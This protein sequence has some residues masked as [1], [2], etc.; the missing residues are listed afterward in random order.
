MQSKY[1]ESP[2]LGHG[3]SKAVRCLKGL[4]FRGGRQ[5]GQGRGEGI[6]YYHLSSSS[7]YDSPWDEPRRSSD[8]SEICLDDNMDSNLFDTDF[9]ERQEPHEDFTELA[10]VNGNFPEV[11]EKSGGVPELSETNED[12]SEMINTGQDFPNTTETGQDVSGLKCLNVEFL[13]IMEKDENL[14]VLNKMDGDFVECDESSGSFPEITGPCEEHKHQEDDGDFKV[15]SEWPAE[16]SSCLH[17]T[18][19][20]T[21]F[22]STLKL[23]ENP[24]SELERIVTVRSNP[25][26]K[27]AEETSRGCQLSG[28]RTSVEKPVSKR[29]VQLCKAVKKEKSSVQGSSALV[30]VKQRGST[31]QSSR[32]RSDRSHGCR[33]KGDKKS[34]SHRGC[35]MNDTKMKSRGDQVRK[36][37]KTRPHGDQA[38]DD[39]SK[40]SRGVQATRD[41]TKDMSSERTLQIYD[42]RARLSKSLSWLLR[43]SAED[44]GLTL[45][46][47]GFLPVED[48]LRVPAFQGYSIS[49]IKDVV[50]NDDK[51]R[52]RLVL[53]HGSW[54]IKANS[55]HTISI[56]GVSGVSSGSHGSGRLRRRRPFRRDRLVTLSRFLAKILRHTAVSNGLNVMKGGFL[57][58]DDLLKLS[59]LRH[60]R[61]EDV[62]KVVD[63]D[64]KTRFTLSPDEENLM[65]KIRANRGHTLSFELESPACVRRTKIPV[66]K[67]RPSTR[68]TEL[69]V[70]TKALLPEVNYDQ[71]SEENKPMNMHV[72]NDWEM[73]EEVSVVVEQ[74]QVT[75]CK[76][77][78]KRELM[79][80]KEAKTGLAQKTEFEFPMDTDHDEKL[81]DS[82]KVKDCYMIERDSVSCKCGSDWSLDLLSNDLLSG[83]VTMTTGLQDVQ[84][85]MKPEKQDASI[86][87]E[88][89][90][91][92]LPEEQVTKGPMTSKYV[93]KT[94]Y[95]SVKYSRMDRESLKTTVIKVQQNEMSQGKVEL[96][97]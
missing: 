91:H 95:K 5:C 83:E 75:E 4:A 55:G 54:K 40:K 87:V 36:D 63:N 21:N 26:V 44:Y 14:L 30:F 56:S 57:Y 17:N 59:Y 96:L 13:E 82:W 11:M 16:K 60:Y 43:H 50:I 10:G 97:T 64:E 2:A 67:S 24:S 88:Y 38:R 35:D 39:E 66:P 3:P 1:H 25:C 8:Y 81:G 94:I 42:P 6:Q 45:M 73:S 7:I 70:E 71:N 19:F 32:R 89:E 22:C 80:M 74:T 20:E 52:F 86:K 47:G 29:T 46:S 84:P 68:L 34:N 18:N 49:D 15:I 78:K 72:Q 33:M 85:K 62:K 92:S 76:Y 93:Q 90:E 31:T 53:D 79:E 9:A 65:W 58:V 37:V 27:A 51:K 23:I 48:V 61:F 28:A 12:F 41:K 69:E 77:E